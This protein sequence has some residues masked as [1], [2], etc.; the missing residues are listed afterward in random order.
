MEAGEN[1]RKPPRHGE[2]GGARQADHPSP[3]K[4]SPQ[5]GNVSDPTETGGVELALRHAI[6]LLNLP[7]WER[8][9]KA[10]ANKVRIPSRITSHAAQHAWQLD[11]PHNLSIP[12]EPIRGP[13]FEYRDWKEY[14]A[15]VP[16]PVFINAAC[17]ALNPFRPVEQTVEE[18]LSKT[19]DDF[20]AWNSSPESMVPSVPVETP[21]RG[22]PPGP[23]GEPKWPEQAPPGTESPRFRFLLRLAVLYNRFFGYPTYSRIIDKA[24]TVTRIET[25]FEQFV[26]AVL[27][28]CEAQGKI[29]ECNV[30]LPSFDRLKRDQMVNTL[31]YFKEHLSQGANSLSEPTR[32]ALVKFFK[33]KRSKNQI[34]QQDSAS[35][36]QLRERIQSALRSG[37]RKGRKPKQ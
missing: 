34:H 13:R 23:C 30:S 25:P 5:G 10:W 35:F 32:N 4:S 36:V 24:K 20:I 27:V 7:E 11:S 26:K 31:R 12:G 3:R 37:S 6:E 18:F 17:F 9:A 14:F 15:G 28:L 29:V 1:Q 21:K 8:N 16:Q 19:I 2:G 22:R 33:I